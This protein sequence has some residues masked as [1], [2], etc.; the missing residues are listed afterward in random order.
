MEAEISKMEEPVSSLVSAI[1]HV[2]H[3][4]ETSPVSVNLKEKQKKI[5][6]LMAFLKSTAES[7]HKALDDSF[8]ASKKFWPGIDKLQTVL[9][10]VRTALDS[11]EEPHIDPTSIQGL[12]R[13]HE[14]QS[15]LP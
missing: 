9:Q 14:V 2:C 10:D 1:D 7:R 13:E 15:F 12:L 8:E 5:G 6:S 11:E 4:D 3:E